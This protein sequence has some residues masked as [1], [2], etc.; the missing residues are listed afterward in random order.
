MARDYGITETEY[1][2]KDLYGD[3]PPIFE[4]ITLVSNGSTAVDL[5]KGTVL[6]KVTASGKYIGL[7]PDGADGSEAAV[8]VLGEDVTV[9]ATGDA[10]SFACVHGN[11]RKSELEWTHDGITTGEQD[12]AYAELKAL[13][14]FPF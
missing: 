10:K 6:A 11:V 4:P 5:I 3:H 8:C 9:P 2:E 1:T 14:I 7:D 12:T 13:T